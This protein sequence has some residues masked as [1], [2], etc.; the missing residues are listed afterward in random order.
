MMN[1][2]CLNFLF[3]FLIF[4]ILLNVLP[5]FGETF[6]EGPFDLEMF[7]DLRGIV[8]K[9]EGGSLVEMDLS[10]KLEILKTCT[11][12]TFTQ[13][14]SK[15]RMPKGFNPDEIIVKA[16]NPGLGIRSLH[17][18][19]I[20]GE[21]IKVA[22]IDQ[23]LLLTHCEY[24]DKVSKYMMIDCET[25]PPQMHGASVASLLVGNNCGVAPGAS[26]FYWAEPSWK[27]DYK[28][29]TEALRQIIN[30]NESK[31]DGEKIRVVSVSIG[32]N[33]DFRNLDLWKKTLD[34]AKKKNLIVIH[35]SMDMYGVGC[36]SDKDPDDASNYNICFFAA[37]GKNRIPARFIYVPIDNRTT[38]SYE[39]DEGYVFWGR[40]GLSWGAP[41]LAGVIALGLQVDGTL[42]EEE[43]FGFLR[44]TGT[45]FNRGV[46]V[47]PVK[48]IGKVRE[49]KAG[50]GK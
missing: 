24:K 17:K 21:G 31:P 37:K 34:E 23:P 10:N 13:W 22:I 16:Q 33:E 4:I 12:D 49:H 39:G 27:R 11:F 38:A 44:D 40:G 2:A 25:A 6:I 1:K 29:R 43:I 19:G 3:S 47:N 32:F 9:N 5:S 36:P 41:Y 35:C 7:D 14:P 42:T 30:Y 15:D 28:Q 45:P 20:R 48:F 8:L 50:R 26:L 46:I 18:Q